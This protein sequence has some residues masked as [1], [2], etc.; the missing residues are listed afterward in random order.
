MPKIYLKPFSSSSYYGFLDSFLIG[1]QLS[2][3]FKGSDT[4]VQDVVS[5]I[6]DLSYL[7]NNITDWSLNSLE[8][9]LMNFTR[10][11]ASNFSASLV[12]CELMGENA[13]A[14]VYS[15]GA[16][17]PNGLGDL[18]MSFL[19]NMMGNALKFKSIFD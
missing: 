4:C 17:F 11:V 15:K 9:P 8:A 12:D 6:D 16:E 10:L 2:T 14:Y 1:I 3:F 19:F 13:V 5:T 18:F 7:A